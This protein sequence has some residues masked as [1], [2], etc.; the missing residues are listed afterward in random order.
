MF[1]GR[2]IKTEEKSSQLSLIASIGY[3]E[4]GVFVLFLQV[5][6]KK[7]DCD[8]TKSEDKGTTI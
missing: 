4:T 6:A 5:D 8:Q 3:S 2:Q 1:E 7:G